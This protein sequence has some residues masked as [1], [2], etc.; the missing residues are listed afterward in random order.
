MAKKILLVE[1]EP[2]IIELARIRLENSGYDVTVAVDGDEAIKVIKKIKPD[3]VLL[4]LLL[5]KNR[6]E[7]VCR[8]I[9]ADERL[10]DVPIIIFTAS[11]CNIRDKTLEMGAAD[12]IMK[13]FEPAELM[14]KIKSF[15]G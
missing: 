1:D 8:Q 2:D 10:K 3:L 6:G 7:E 5:P 13:P 9:K 14:Q 15:I 11:A 4:D 12:Y